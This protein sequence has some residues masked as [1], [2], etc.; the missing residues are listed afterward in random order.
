M[1]EPM[2]LSQ[3]NLFDFSN[4][5]SGVM[6]LFP[7]VWGALE[8]VISDDVG[9]RKRGLDKLIDL[10]A[11]RLSPLVAYVLVTCITDTDLD[12]R[13]KIVQT[14][15]GLLS[16]EDTQKT[17]SESVVQSLKRYLSKMRRRKIYSLLE[18]AAFYPSSI[19]H[20][21]ALLKA[22]SHAGGTLSDIF[23]DRK[24]PIEIRREAINLS[25]IVGYLDVIPALE[26]LA[27]RLESRME[28]QRS[29]PFAPPVDIHEKS[30]LSTV[31]TSLT[32]LNSP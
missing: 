29:M 9:V 30:L 28:G 20:V 5:T 19:S 23:S 10:G 26:R 2:K 11:H 15:G 27:G 21:A 4:T 25:G 18:I 24:I 8:G 12:F 17:P 7:S 14:I 32:I 16:K 1:I 31:Q 6:E 22:C 13:F 3:P